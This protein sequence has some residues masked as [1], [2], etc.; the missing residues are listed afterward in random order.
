VIRILF[1]EIART[2]GQVALIRG[3]NDRFFSAI[4][5]GTRKT[6]RR[7]GKVR[8][9]RILLE[10]PEDDERGWEARRKR[11]ETPAVLCA[12]RQEKSGHLEKDAR[13]RLCMALSM[14][15]HST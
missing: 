3:G 6:E 10:E 12:V 13:I 14:E 7:N 4:E 8:N 5:A 9:L 15:L 2:E 11:L 1:G